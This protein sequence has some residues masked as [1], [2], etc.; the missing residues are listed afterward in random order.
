MADLS[1]IKLNGTTYNFKDSW[2]RTN[3]QTEAQ[4]NTAITNALGNIT[5]FSVEVVQSLPAT[6]EQGVFYFVSNSGSGNNIYDEYVYVN[7]AFEKIGTTEIDLSNY[8][9][10][11]DIAD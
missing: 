4:V 11:T 3:L 9:Q 2:A 1:K 5:G 7:S 8:L 6:G 10:T